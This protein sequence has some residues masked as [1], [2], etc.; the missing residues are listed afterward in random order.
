M[1]LVI[2]PD[3]SVHC[4]YGEAI[5]LSA[6]GRPTITRASNVEPDG[7]GRWWADLAPIGGPMFGPFA[8][9]SDAIAAEVAYLTE[10]LHT[11]KHLHLR[12][13]A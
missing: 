10:R 1:R 13:P 7:K 3:G 9:R 8:K 2:E 4:L 12:Q 5:D 11:I 6:L